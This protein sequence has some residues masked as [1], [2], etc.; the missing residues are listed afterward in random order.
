MLEMLVTFQKGFGDKASDMLKFPD[1]YPDEDRF[2]RKHGEFCQIRVC[3]VPLCHF[4]S[5]L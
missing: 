4:S 5:P 2:V 3:F 1:I